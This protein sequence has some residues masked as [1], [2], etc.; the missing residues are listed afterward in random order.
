MGKTSKIKIK[1][2]I[3]PSL[4][5]NT[6]ASLFFKKINEMPEKE[7]IIDFTDVIFMSRSFAQEYCYQKSGSV[8]NIE[9]IN[10][11]PDVESVFSIVDKNF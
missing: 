6:A 10:M 2:F 5:F 9:E 7:F 11:S 3:N 1:N 4:E 8:K